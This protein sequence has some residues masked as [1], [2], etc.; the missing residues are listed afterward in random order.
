V[1][2]RIAARPIVTK[3]R[4]ALDDAVR[5]FDAYFSGLDAEAKANKLLA[6]VK[7]ALAT[8]FFNHWYSALLLCEAGMMV[9]VLIC[10]RSAMETLAFHW[11]ICIDS[12]TGEEYEAGKRLEPVTVRKRLETLGVDVS[13]I[14]ETYSMG[15]AFAHV[16]RESERFYL[17]MTDDTE[18]RLFIG[19]NFSKDDGE[20]WFAY[21][22]VLLHL[23]HHPQMR[24]SE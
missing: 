22:P 7:K 4:R 10:E 12:S 5:A 21:F 6:N 8:R 3:H 13:Y 17:E 19:G 18:G 15:S 16:R 2:I 23:F 20:H 14:R 11:L 24:G 9:D 1:S